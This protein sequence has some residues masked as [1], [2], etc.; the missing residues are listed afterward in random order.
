VRDDHDVALLE[1]VGCVAAVMGVGY[2]ARIGLAPF[3]S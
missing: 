1:Q 2:L 3:E